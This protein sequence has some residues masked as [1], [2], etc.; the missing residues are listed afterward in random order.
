MQLGLCP[1]VEG[2][3]KMWR[4][5]G[6]QA[7]NRREWVLTHLADIHQSITTVALYDTLGQDAIRFVVAQT[8]LSTIAV[9]I[10]YVKKLAQ[11]KID[12]MKMDE[13]KMTT[14]KN[15][16]VFENALT[17]EDKEIAE[18]AGIS[19]YTIDELIQIGKDAKPEFKVF[20]EPK[21]DD[22]FAFSYTSGTTGDPKGVKLTHKMIIG[23]A[24]AV[25]Q[26]VGDTPVTENDCYISYLPAAHSFEQAVFGMS[27]ISGMKAGFF[28]GNVLK[29]T[30]DI[31][32]LKPTLFPSVPRLY[33]RIYGKIM[34][35]IK[36]A[37]GV[38]GWLVNKAVTSKLAYLKAGQGFEHKFYDKV[39]FKKM[40]TL[41]GGRVRIMITGSAPIS[42]EVLDFLKICFSAPLCEGYGMTETCAGSCITFLNDPETGIVGGPLQNVKI[43]LRD[44]PEM[45]YMSTDDPPRGEICFWG[46]SI[47]KGYYKNPEKTAE[48]F[49]NDWLL[50]GDVG[51]IKPN[52]A[53]KVID[54]AKN[55]FK[56]SQGEYIAPE[57]LENVYVQS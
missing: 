18:Q 31:G 22:C 5:M 25:N 14:L 4:F 11:L 39:V 10:E 48:A 8:E 15:L 44:L 57:K 36:A 2:E 42:A 45:G 26:R 40:K 50:S 47:M 23:A 30:E 19:L 46:P 20:N 16:I 28:A 53:I 49:H 52:G 12:D 56:L 55:I 29:L 3:D 27:C 54:R 1:E 34:D 17:P 37:T 7:K 51:L 24:F 9:S 33:N 43:R 38:K 6:I 35:G 32:V 41:L 13:Q 21:T